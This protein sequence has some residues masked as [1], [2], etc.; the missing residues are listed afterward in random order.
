[1]EK[2]NHIKITGLFLIIFMLS[3]CQHNKKPIASSDWKTGKSWSFSGKMAINDGQNSGSGRI[4]WETYNNTTHAEFKAPLGQGSWTITE[5]ANTAKLVSSKNGKTI[6]DNA[7]DLISNELG[8][9]FPWKSLKYWVRGYQTGQALTP[10]NTLPESFSD[11]GW[12]ITFQKW[13]KTAKGMLPK[14]IKA[15]KDN[16]SVKLIIYSWD[17]SKK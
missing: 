7:S 4:S 11:N 14:K 8:W 13:T 17:F 16:Y 6:A 5:N 2:K 1:M 3:A 9:H 10:Y 15:S 12:K